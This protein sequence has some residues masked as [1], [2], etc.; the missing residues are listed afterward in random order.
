MTTEQVLAV[1]DQSAVYDFVVSR[2][3]ADL[4]II[5]GQY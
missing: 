2:A 3:V 4:M 5:Y 1:V